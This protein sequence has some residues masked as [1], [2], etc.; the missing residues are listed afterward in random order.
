MASRQNNEVTREFNLPGYIVE[1][2]LL[3]Q[4]DQTAVAGLAEHG[5]PIDREFI[6]A[7]IT[8][9]RL[10]FSSLD[11]LH[12]CLSDAPREIRSITMRYK[13]GRTSGIQ[14]VI[15]NDA[16]IRVY[17]F[18][19]NLDFEFNLDQVCEVIKEGQ[20]EYSWAVRQFVFQRRY[21]R[22]SSFGLSILSGA[23]P[24]LVGFY[25]YAA[26]TGVNIDPALIP[27]GYESA[28]RIAEALK[29]P[30]ITKKLD[31]LLQSQL[32]GFTNISVVLL[33]M[34]R[35]LLICIILLIVLSVFTGICKV[36]EG[37]YPRCFFLFGHNEKMWKRLETKRQVWGIAVVIG[38]IINIAAGAVVAL[39]TR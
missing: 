16:F 28:R 34:N 25:I 31:A 32:H 37:L 5:Q 30:D 6:V 14:I 20:E 3:E 35:L 7:K 27:R 17:G 19:E 24:I 1:Q 38:F 2:E 13:A 12:T 11:Q 4:I 18:G 33:F 8:K 23:I 26:N 22:L 29:S 36:F 21:K 9:A 10:T 15:S 39:V